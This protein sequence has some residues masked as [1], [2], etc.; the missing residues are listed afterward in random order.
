M[1]RLRHLPTLALLGLAPLA[2]TACDSGGDDKSSAKGL[3][4]LQGADRLYIEIKSSEVVTYDY[5][6]DSVDNGPDCYLIES[7]DLEDVDGDEYTI[8]GETATVTV[9]DDVLTI[10][11]DGGTATKWNRSDDDTDD[12]RDEECA[13]KTAA[14]KR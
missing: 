11:P 12:F 3:W 1:H 4:E 7:A 14:A 6:G 5:L 10:R 8:D 9:D 2:L 13:G